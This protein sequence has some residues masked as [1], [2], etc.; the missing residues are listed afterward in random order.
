M[1]AFPRSESEQDLDRKIQAVDRILKQIK[2]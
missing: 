2:A 1:S